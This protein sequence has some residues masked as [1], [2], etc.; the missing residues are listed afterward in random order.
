MGGPT[1]WERTQSLDHCNRTCMHGLP[2]R[3]GRVVGVAGLGDA[4]KFGIIVGANAGLA[5][6]IN[7][8]CVARN[9]SHWHTNELKGKGGLTPPLC[10]SWYVGRRVRERLRSLD[11]RYWCRRRRRESF[12]SSFSS[13]W[14]VHN[15][16]GRASLYGWTVV[17]WRWCHSWARG[18]RNFLGLLFR[19]EIWIRLAEKKGH[20]R[21]TGCQSG[22]Y[23]PPAPCFDLTAM[24]SAISL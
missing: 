4:G 21:T 2:N 10:P 22:V 1:K 20:W 5:I 23:S 3:P 13:G 16:P 19:Y 24:S 18:W 14:L 7:R 9:I 12:G 17:H 8:T 6:M 11:L 15:A